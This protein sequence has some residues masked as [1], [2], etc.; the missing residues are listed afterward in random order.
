MM[1]AFISFC[2]HVFHRPVS[3]FHHISR[4]FAFPRSAIVQVSIPPRLKEPVLD[5]ILPPA[6][7]TTLEPICQLF[8]AALSGDEKYD[9]LLHFSR[10]HMTT[11]TLR[12]SQNEVP[13][14]LSKVWITVEKGESGLLQLEADAESLIIRGVC[15]ILVLGLSKS[16]TEQVLHLDGDLLAKRLNIDSLLS[17]SRMNGINTLLDSIT[18]KVMLMSS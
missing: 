6:L 14:C 5:A 1:N 13:G 17:S 15:A 4:S 9:L 3:S 8:D 10:N 16:P 18:T 12:C 2:C 11:A 7:P